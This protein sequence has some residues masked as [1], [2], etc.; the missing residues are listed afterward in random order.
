MKKIK[1]RITETSNIPPECLTEFPP[2]PK[3]VKI[4]VTSRCDLKCSF[5]SVTYNNQKGR[6]I[7]RELL[8]KILSELSENGVEEVGLFWLGEPLL[9]SAL[10]EYVAFAKNVGMKYVFIT[11]NGRLATPDRV[12]PLIE[13][14][15]DSIKFSINVSNKEQYIKLCGVDAFDRV[16]SNLKS[17]WEI[18]GDKRT[19]SIYASTIF[20]PN[21]NKT[22]KEISSLIY[23]YVD[24]HYPLRMYGKMTYE[25]QLMDSEQSTTELKIEPRSLDS[26][27]PCWALFTLP[28]ISYDGFLSAC[29]CDHDH[30]FFI[31]N[32]ND[33]SFKDAWYSPKLVALRKKHLEKDVKGCVCENCIAYKH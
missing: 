29:Y 13:S 17:T 8:F 15:I 28:H 11:T 4:E 24:Q 1:E 25:E 6:D 10:S 32:L 3:S 12:I 2:L 23:P 26:M 5:C 20:D 27:L 14:G 33:V 19:P 21:D 30:R 9:V 7:D 22:F 16:I 18:R 31:E